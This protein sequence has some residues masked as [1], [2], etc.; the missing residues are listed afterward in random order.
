[1]LAFL[2]GLLFVI[3]LI[4]IGLNLFAWV[5]KRTRRLHLWVAG[6]TV[7]SWLVLGIWYGFGYCFLTDWEWN[8]KRQLGEKNLPHS[9]TQYLSD[10]VF[11]LY[12]STT[13]V[14]G[15]TLGLFV[16]AIICSLYL[17]FFKRS[18]IKQ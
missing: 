4:V 16:I 6:T 11:G 15:L 1:M 17:N 3:H 9:F 8:I 12:L 18:L 7:F 5:W 10:N 2:D 14:D 13:I